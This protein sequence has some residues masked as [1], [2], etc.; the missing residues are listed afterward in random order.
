MFS[1]QSILGC[2]LL[3]SSVTA[4]VAPGRTTGTVYYNAASGFSLKMGVL[5]PTGVS[6]GSYTDMNGTA[7]AFG[8]LSITTTSSSGAYNDTIQMF[9]AGYLE[10]ALTMSRI[11][12]HLINVF[13]WLESQFKNGI[14]PAIDQ[15]FITQDAYARANV[16]SNTSSPIW[17]STGLLLSQMD[18]LYAGYNAQA[19]VSGGRPLTM[20]DFQKIN[21][22]GDFLDLIPA[23]SVEDSW[24]WTL[25]T[26]QELIDRVRKTTHC[27]AFVKVTGDL[28]E[29]YFSHAAWFIWQSTTVSVI[30]TFL[31]FSSSI[32]PL[33]TS[34]YLPSLF[35]IED[36]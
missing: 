2:G 13:Q 26:D 6:W 5:D 11:S 25:M 10:G 33:L 19:A 24:D 30:K 34:S 32:H 15:F 21:A 8:Q 23:L 28:S 1:L 27:S 36:L 18:G 4:Q 3:L 22:I 35:S 16:A 12:S 14:P 20:Y 7:S 31:L 29:M 17:Q 9:A